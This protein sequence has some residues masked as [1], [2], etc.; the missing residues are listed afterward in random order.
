MIRRLLPMLLLA[1]AIACSPPQ[2]ASTAEQLTLYAASTEVR[3]FA[4]PIGFV[5]PEGVSLEQIVDRQSGALLTPDEAVAVSR[6]VSVTPPPDE[7]ATCAHFWRHLFVFYGADGAPL[8]ALA[9]CVECGAVFVIGPEDP[10]VG[11]EQLRYDG[12]R[13]SG[14]VEAHGLSV[15]PEYPE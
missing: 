11:H 2:Q 9:Y 6:S 14:I 7:V 4:D 10:G 12:A 5:F 3:L 8:G 13:L 15:E 1:S